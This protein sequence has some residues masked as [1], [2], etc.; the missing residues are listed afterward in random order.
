MSGV[1]WTSTVFGMYIM[2]LSDPMA[3]N[4]FVACSVVIKIAL[5]FLTSICVIE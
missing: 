3:H 5:Q 4:T 1:L 2:K